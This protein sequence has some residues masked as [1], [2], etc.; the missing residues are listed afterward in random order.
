V[1][2]EALRAVFN[3][4]CVD[5]DLIHQLKHLLTVGGHQW[6]NKHL[7]TVSTTLIHSLS[8]WYLA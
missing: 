4:G 8:S 7:I 5:I 3:K 1:L 6:F 2:V